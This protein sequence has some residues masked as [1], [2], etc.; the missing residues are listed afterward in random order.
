MN[1]ADIPVL[2]IMLAIP[3]VVA[4]MCLFV[5]AELARIIA[6]SAT[7]LNLVLG[8]VLWLNY[9]PAGAQWQFTESATVFGPIGWRLGIDGISLT[10]IM[11]SVFLMPICARGHEHF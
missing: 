5:R 4:A 1:A 7:L 8:L 3:V 6:L 2:S 9:D 10:L 11:L